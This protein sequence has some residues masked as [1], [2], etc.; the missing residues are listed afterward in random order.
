MTDN[1]YDDRSYMANTAKGKKKER[2]IW[3]CRRDCKVHYPKKTIALFI[4]L[5]AVF[6]STLAISIILITRF[7]PRSA[8]SISCGFA[9]T[10]SLVA[11]AVT[12]GSFKGHLTWQ[13]VFV[14]DE[15]GDVYYID[16]TDV[17]PAKDFLY[18]DE[19]PAGYKNEPG[20]MPSNTAKAVG[21]TYFLVFFPKECKR[22][23][24]II[25]DNKADIRIAD[26]CRKYGYKIISVPE[27]IKKSY[28]TFIRFNILKDGNMVEVE[29]L[30]D[31]CYEGYDEMVEYLDE[32]FEHDDEDAREDKSSQIRK[33]LYIGSVM[34]VIS[35]RIKCCKFRLNSTP[36]PVE[37]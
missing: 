11:L 15:N 27:I 24:N 3:Q 9:A 21:I 1:T 22:C 5:C 12:A 33:L 25:R 26:S 14:R 30:F 17:S 35:I 32:H 18:Y 10:F 20:P 34:I 16:Y 13:H 31:N 2:T 7:D 19:I 28:Y 6:I 36:I 29:N 8:V 23:L 4:S 37:R